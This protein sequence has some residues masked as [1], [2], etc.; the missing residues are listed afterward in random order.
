M[1]GFPDWWS[2][3]AYL[4]MY[5]DVAAAVAKKLFASGYQHYLEHGEKEGRRPGVHIALPLDWREADYLQANSD[6]RQAVFQGKFSSGYEHFHS[7]GRFEKRKFSGDDDSVTVE[8]QLGLPHW[9]VEEMEIVKV[10][11]P[12]LTPRMGFLG[13]LKKFEIDSNSNQA[14]IDTYF[15]LLF[16]LKKKSYSHLFLLPWV[17]KG[18]SDLELINIMKVLAEKQGTEIAL[19]VSERTTSEWI[20]RVPASVDIF[21][22]G[23]DKADLN[24]EE[25]TRLL[26]RF[27]TQERPGV[28][29]VSNCTVGW[30]L[31]TRHGRAVSANSRMFVSLF[32]YDYLPNGQPV[33]YA[34]DLGSAAPYLTGIIVDNRTYADHVI[35][36]YGVI[37]ADVTA[38]RFPVDSAVAFSNHDNPNK[39]LWASRLDRQK[40][41]WLVSA[42]AKLDRSIEIEMF[43]S[44]V[45]DSED[46]AMDAISSQP[47][48]TW[49][50]AYSGFNSIPRIGYSCFLYTSAWDGLPNV[51]LEVMSSGLPLITANVGGIAEIVDDSVGYLVDDHDNPIAYLEVINS[52]RS[53]PDVAAEKAT[54]AHERVMQRHS[55]EQFRTSIESI[56]KYVS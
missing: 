38:V 53:C 31:L 41:P 7:M 36:Q 34:R 55:W 45:L 23:N 4:R 30:R 1:S 48:V 11:E 20:S 13:Q 56:K 3:I 9:L 39:I 26:L 8:G 44:A 24:L 15:R 50:G 14:F 27:I 16:S 43:G 17:K 35:E 46:S 12:A 40:R 10:I 21:D 51:V 2:E 19:I 18:G 47:N 37:A 33:G 49:R 28:V 22:L 25:K 52:L 32:C 6:V 29:H 42:I 5:P 54:R